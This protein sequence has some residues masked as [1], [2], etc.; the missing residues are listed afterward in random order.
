MGVALSID[1]F[2]TGY[3][4]LSYLKK[5]PVNAVKIDK[6]FVINMTTDQNDAQIV[7]STIDLAHNLGL[8]VIAEGVETREV[9]DRLTVLGCDEAQGYYMSRPL[10]ASGLTQWM[11]DSPWGFRNG[12]SDCE[13]QRRVGV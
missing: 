4:S 1:D 8:K 13:F 12:K 11:F 6:S 10:P 3:S 5:L 9:W 7:R 2:G